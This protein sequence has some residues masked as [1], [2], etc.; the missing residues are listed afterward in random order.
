MD[1]IIRPAGF[2]IRLLALI[3]DGLIIGIPLGILGSMVQNSAFALIINLIALAYYIVLPPY[4]NGYTIGKKIM[5][6]RIVKLYGDKV[7]I[8]T[9]LMRYLVSWLIY[10]ITIGIAAIVSAFM[11]AFRKDKRSIHD[12][13]AKTYVTYEKP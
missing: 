13:L 2:W 5:G 8:G 12:L 7:G 3:L 4:W 10:A 1:N 11:V 6:I 9:M